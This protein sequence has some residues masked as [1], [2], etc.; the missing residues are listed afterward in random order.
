MQSS[1]TD[2]VSV[3]LAIATFKPEQH[4]WQNCNDKSIHAAFHAAVT[5][6]DGNVGHSVKSRHSDF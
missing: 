1:H 2:C 6:G 3:Y 4:Q 5:E